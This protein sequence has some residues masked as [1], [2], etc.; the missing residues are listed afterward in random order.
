V[1]D[2]AKNSML[3]MYL[4]RR[5]VA[6][7][8][9]YYTSKGDDFYELHQSTLPP[10]MTVQYDAWFTTGTFERTGDEYGGRGGVAVEFNLTVDG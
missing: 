7:A 3:A 6:L 10:L 4:A 1:L 5:G 2:Q 9:R 8:M